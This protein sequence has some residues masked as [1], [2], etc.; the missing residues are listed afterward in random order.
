LPRILAT[1]NWDT[2]VADRF[3]FGAEQIVEEALMIPKPGGPED[4]WVL[5]PTLN[6]AA[7]ASELHLFEVG[8]LS[9]GP[10]ASLRADVAV[11]IGFHGT[12]A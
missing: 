9:A 8:R 5:V 4:A 6:L 11:P 12:W 3:D 2:G 10:I 7:H 1:W